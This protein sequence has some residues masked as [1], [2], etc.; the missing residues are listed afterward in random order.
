MDLLNFVSFDTKQKKD[1]LRL[2]SF[3]FTIFMIWFGY[4]LFGAIYL[5]QDIW[6]HTF[7][8]AGFGELIFIG[9]PT[10]FYL[11][12][13]ERVKLIAFLKLNTIT[14]IGLKFVIVFIFFYIPIR[15]ALLSYVDRSI[16]FNLFFQ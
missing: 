5:G 8:D 2:I 4:C 3:I 12:H 16:Q 9:L 11:K 14:K 13:F 10:I 15:L 6:F 7:H 1:S